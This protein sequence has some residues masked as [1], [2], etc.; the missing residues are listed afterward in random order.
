MQKG[1]PIEQATLKVANELR[2]YATAQP[3]W[4]GFLRKTNRLA[5]NAIKA[6]ELGVENP[7][8]P[9]AFTEQETV[10]KQDVF[11]KLES[12]NQ[13]KSLPEKKPTLEELRKNFAI[14]AARSATIKAA[15]YWGYK[16][17]DLGE[18]S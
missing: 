6:K 8:L 1:E 14:P 5:D 2:N 9:A 3:L 7:Y 16:V 13:Q 11:D 10:T 18:A 17:A 4:E 15:E 12:L